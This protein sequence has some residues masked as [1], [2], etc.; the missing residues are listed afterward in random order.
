MSDAMQHDPSRRETKKE[1]FVSVEL[2]VS[3]KASMGLRKP[4]PP[5][6]RKKGEKRESLRAS[7]D[8]QKKLKEKSSWLTL[9]RT[10]AGAGSWRPAT[11]RLSEEEDGCLMNVYIDETTLYQ[12]IYVHLLNHTDI[13]PADRSLFYRKDCVGIHCVSGQRWS[14][15]PSSEPLYLH[16]KNTEAA[17]TWVTLMRSYAMPEI[18]GRYFSPSDGGLYRMWRQ[19]E[20]TI[21]QGRNLGQSK[22][23]DELAIANR[24]A[25]DP[26]IDLQLET[27]GADMDVY[28][29]VY[30]NEVLSGRTTTKRCPGSTDWHEA[31]AFCDLPP[32]ENLEIL[33]W[34][35][36]KLTRPILM[37]NI[38]VFLS[39]FRRGET[40]EGW[41]P[42]LFGDM[43][44]PSIHVGD[45]RLKLKVD[46][47]IILPL[48]AYSDLLETLYSRN[49]LDWMSDLEGRL[50]LTSLSSQV[51]SISI[52]RNVLLD[53]IFELADREVDG[54]PHSHNTLFRGNTV[55]TKTMEMSMAWY[56]K[57]FLE[58]SIGPV[59]RRLYAERI[60][61]EIDPARSQGR[62]A[63]DIERNVD[64]L[65]YWCQEV[66]GNIY[67]MRGECPV[68]MR[69][70]F[71]H[72]RQLVEKRYQVKDMPN[73]KGR[74][75][76]WQSVSAFCFLRFFVPAI[77]HPHLFGLCPGLPELSVQRSLT[78]IA[79]VIQSLANLNASVQR[80]EF[81]RGVKNFLTSSLPA[82]ID[83]I[84]VV[85][86]LES[87]KARGPYQYSPDRHER[88]H[89][90]NSLQRRGP[91]MPLLHR[92]AIPLLPHLLDIPRHLAIITSA[93]IRHSR[94]YP[95]QSSNDPAEAPLDAFCARCFEIEQRA[96]HRV[97]HLAAR[98][99]PSDPL[100]VIGTPPTRICYPLS[101]RQN[102]R[103]QGPRIILR[104]RLQL[105]V[106]FIGCCQRTR[107]V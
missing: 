40:V 25:E 43:G 44:A 28:C 56:G 74:E 5:P 86:T 107:L 81:M 6:P 38:Q 97:S 4:V 106:T 61:I 82:M 27:D 65:V 79:K 95:R 101:H 12:T 68:E 87:E 2:F 96:L 30:I 35:E 13:R 100:S 69:R 63:K 47:E 49:C 51:L 66:W 36:K 75:L 71:S 94:S 102:Y 19:V 78:L 83:Y 59:I 21:I 62:S 84:L 37:G 26:G 16:F 18:Y 50:Q 93:V 48:S 52:A 46:E 1:F 23:Y 80:E 9:S 91:G 8:S 39:D 104:H 90:M 42:V 15:L 34:R 20:L 76:P 105:P 32:F 77:L 98:H 33:I 29:E 64:Q 85:S 92:E 11:C 58:A 10:A 24:G 54:T 70:L 41:F 88:L 67:S 17:N 55:L 45:L 89:V 103:T 14:V 60:T 73:D 22:L 53:H 72:I 99:K 57:G 3:N 7:D 31:F